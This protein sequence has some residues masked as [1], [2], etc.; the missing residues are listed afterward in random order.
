MKNNRKAKGALFVVAIIA[1][2]LLVTLVVMQLWN[3]LLPEIVGA[4]TINYW[5]AMGI[6][7]L[8]KILFGGFNGGKHKIEH[9]KNKHQYNERMNEMSEDEKEKF[10]EKLKERFRNHPFCK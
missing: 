3:C 8:S 10:K 1:I 6:L 5:Q 4:K 7:V 2:F 9:W